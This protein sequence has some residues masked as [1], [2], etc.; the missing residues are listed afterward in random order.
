MP[1]G[2]A[3][4]RAEPLLPERSW[5]RWIETGAQSLQARLGGAVDPARIRAE[6]QAEFAVFS[7]ARVRDFVPILV[8]TRVRSRLLS[9]SPKHDDR[10]PDHRELVFHPR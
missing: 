4:A 7:G 3:G 5:T 9:G 8:E 2:D 6:V 10:Q 1:D